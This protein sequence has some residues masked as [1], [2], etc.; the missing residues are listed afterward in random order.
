[1]LVCLMSTTDTYIPFK[2]AVFLYFERT[3]RLCTAQPNR[4]RKRQIIFTCPKLKLIYLTTFCRSPPLDTAK[5]HKL[6]TSRN[7]LWEMKL[8]YHSIH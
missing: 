2:I 8:I 5:R 7:E 3:L 1:M 4:L 6:T